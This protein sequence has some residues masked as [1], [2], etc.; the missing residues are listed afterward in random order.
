M[1]SL[2]QFPTRKCVQLLGFDGIDDVEKF[3]DNYGVRRYNDL[4]TGEEFI[5]ISRVKVADVFVSLPQKVHAWIE[6][7]R[8]GRSLTQ[9]SLQKLNTPLYFV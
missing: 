1:F 2:F 6:A 3:L 5:Y 7:K 9:V 8:N 4:E